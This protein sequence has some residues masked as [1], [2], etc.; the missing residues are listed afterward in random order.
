MPVAGRSIPGKSDRDVAAE[1]GSVRPSLSASGLGA[2]PDGGQDAGYRTRSNPS[3]QM[4]AL[5][6]WIRSPVYFHATGMT[7]DA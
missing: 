4:M 1:S 7:F 6:N 3:L 2:A 5:L